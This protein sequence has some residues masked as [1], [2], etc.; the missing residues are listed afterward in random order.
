MIKKNVI[1]KNL[2]DS[3]GV[4]DAR[5]GGLLRNK[6]ESL[7]IVSDSSI[8][9]L[10][11]GLR[12]HFISLLSEIADLDSAKSDAMNLG[13]SHVLS[14]HKIQF[15]AEKVDTMIIQAIALLDEL[16]KEINIY[17]MRCKE[18]YGWHFPEMTKII[19]ENMQYCRIIT[20]MGFRKNCVDTDLSSILEESTEI[21]LKNMA[22]ISMGSEITQSDLD[23]IKSLATQVCPT[24]I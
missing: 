11:R 14:R 2:N 13:L 18:W 19:N 15:S 1:K 16:D 5:I 3:I 23:N 6:Y 12:E 4:I 21:E 20:T 8:L 24:L 9:E 17:A 7:N 22:K 10:H